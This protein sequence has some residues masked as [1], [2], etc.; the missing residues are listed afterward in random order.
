MP[1]NVKYPSR[2]GALTLFL[3]LA[4]ATATI[5]SGSL[6]AQR[7]SF[8]ERIAEVDPEEA[9]R[10]LEETQVDLSAA[11]DRYIRSRSE[12]DL[13]ELRGLKVRARFYRSKLE[14]GGGFEGIRREAGSILER[15]ERGR[16]PS[17]VAE[18]AGSK[19]VQA[20]MGSAT[21]LDVFA[22]SRPLD[23][24]FS[25][26]FDDLGRMYV[27]NYGED[28]VLRFEADGTFDQ[29]FASGNNLGGPIDIAFDSQAG[30]TSPAPL[31]KRC[32]AGT[33]TGRSTRWSPRQRTASTSPWGLLS[34]QPTICTFPTMGRVKSSIGTKMAC[35]REYSRTTSPSRDPSEWYSTTP[36]GST[37]L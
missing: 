12:T 9:A 5:P 3:F 28:E 11:R 22:E 4:L 34:M 36:E 30:S 24:P 8:V 21:F 16:S 23:M 14:K 29:V 10:K 19:L 35:S 1:P 27:A 2:L 33:P 32:C 13:K 7:I 20:A 15:R 37:W 17:R 6:F 25:V 31:Q 26:A 18:F